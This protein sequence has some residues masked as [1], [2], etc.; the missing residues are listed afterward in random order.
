ME[1]TKPRETA[2]SAS[3]RSVHRARPSGAVER[4]RKA[5]GGELLAV[6]QSRVEGL[7]FLR[8]GDE[9]ARDIAGRYHTQGL[10]GPAATETSFRSHAPGGANLFLAARGK[11]NALSPL[12]SSIFPAP[13][14]EHDG[15]LEVLEIY[16][17]DLTGA[18]LV[19]LSA[20]QTQ[21]GE[22]SRGDDVVGLNRA[23]LYAGTPTVVASLWSVRERQTGDLMTAF[24]NNL[25]DGMSKADALRQA[26]ARV[27]AAH[28]HPYY[29]A[30]FVLTGDPGT[31]TLGQ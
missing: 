27:R 13:D 28:P 3:S 20:F 2:L 16:G 18:D 15:L 4:K 8:Y 21:L 17:L 1:S 29:W 19:V 11:L 22:V 23:F 9:V 26:Q 5:G 25:R 14:K 31:G 7:P 30:A 10:V 12:F 6:A 24:Y